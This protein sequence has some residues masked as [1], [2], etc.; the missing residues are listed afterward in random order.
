MVKEI[1]NFFKILFTDFDKNPKINTEEFLKKIFNYLY[2]IIIFIFLILI[3]IKIVFI[4]LF[5]VKN[6]EINYSNLNNLNYIYFFILNIF[7]KLIF[8]FFFGHVSLYIF[9]FVADYF[10]E[11]K[12]VSLLLNISIFLSGIYI[13]I[14]YITLNNI[15]IFNKFFN[16]L[17]LLN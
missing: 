11:F 15:E 16:L 1:I 13:Y 5:N 9:A 12:L 4:F 8:S 14:Y 2:L 10:K 6:I 7:F 17:I 3:L